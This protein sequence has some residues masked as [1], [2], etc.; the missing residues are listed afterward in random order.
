M[1]SSSAEIE[2]QDT[3]ES[4]EINLV[5]DHIGRMLKRVESTP[6]SG[7]CIYRVPKNI[8]KINEEAYTPRVVS[9][10]PFHYGNE[11]LQSMEVHKLS[12]LEKLIQRENMR[13]VDYV[14]LIKQQEEEI[15]QCYAETIEFESHIFVTM[16]LI[17]AGFIIELLLRFRLPEIGEQDEPLLYKPWLINDIHHDLILLENQLPFFVLKAFF[18]LTFDSYPEFPSLLEVTL[19]FF[20]KYNSQNKIPNSEVRHFT[21]LVRALHLP[22]KRLP[23]N[24]GEFKIL[25][26]ATELHEAG[27]K[28]EV[29]SSRCLLDINFSNGVLRIPCFDLEDNT[30][31]LIRNLMAL[32]VCHYPHDFYIIDYIILMDY[33]INTSK[34][35]DLLIQNGIFRNRLADSSAVATF[36]NNLCTHIT[37]SDSYNFNYSRLC[38]SLNRYH[39]VSWHKWKAIFKRD[40]F[41]SPWRIASTIAAVIFLVLTSIQTICSVL[42]LQGVK[43]V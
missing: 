27:V 37:L 11:R 35:V 1:N 25:C 12:Y 42:S 2:T 38:D 33:L 18:K 30:V 15:R 39:K 40:Y 9:I 23:Q 4:A 31:S 43:L 6:S 10:G 26:S 21:D 16:I 13:L 20:I 36:F 14:R 8:R 17:D 29:G 34:D 28:F 32:E 22:S 41:G 5:M 7:H 24:V 3:A 19:Y